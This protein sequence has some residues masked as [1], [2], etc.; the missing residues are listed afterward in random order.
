[1]FI[2]GAQASPIV[3][4]EMYLETCLIDHH[5]MPIGCSK[6]E[7]IL[8]KNMSSMGYDRVPFPVNCHNNEK[9]VEPGVNL[10]MFTHSMMLIAENFVDIPIQNDYVDE[11]VNE[12][13]PPKNNSFLNG[14]EYEVTFPLFKELNWDA[15]NA[16]NTETLTS[17]SGYWNEANELYEGL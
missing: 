10:A 7:Q 5:A 4:I 11:L 3:S 2:V 9:N 12:D 14:G 8:E 17:H 13:D 6:R 15:I 1:M 16:M